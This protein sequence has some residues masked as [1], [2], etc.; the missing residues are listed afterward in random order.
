MNEAVAIDSWTQFQKFFIFGED[1]FADAVASGAAPGVKTTPLAQAVKGFFDNC[2][3]RCYVLNLGP[4][5][6][7]Q[8]S[9]GARRQ[10]IDVL[11]EIQRH[12]MVCTP[13]ST[14]PDCTRPSS[15]T[16]RGP[17]AWPSATPP[18]TSPT[19]ICSRRLP[20]HPR[21]PRAPA[22]TLR[23]RRGGLRA[24]AAPSGNAAYYY[25]WLTCTN[26]VDS[27]REGA[28]DRAP[29]RAH[30]RSHGPRRYGA[31]RLQ[32]SGQGAVRGALNVVNPV[33]DPEQGG[34]NQKGVNV[35]RL[36]SGTGLRVRGARTLAGAEAPWWRYINVRRTVTM[37]ERSIKR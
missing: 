1:K 8:G 29:F 19:P 11:E 36:F 37:I 9:G 15:R 24:M 28:G 30:R 31:G 3:G 22:R 10:G 34:L 35:I 5:G 26:A 23:R 18:R 32:G 6:S 20:Y 14:T 7:L 2:K 27:V 4:S 25:P 17:T 12:P 16:V 33:T 21:P 13:G